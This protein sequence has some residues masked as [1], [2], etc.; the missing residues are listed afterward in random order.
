MGFGRH[1]LPGFGEGLMRRPVWL[2]ECSCQG[3]HFFPQDMGTTGPNVLPSS[4]RTLRGEN[5]ILCY[6]GDKSQ[7]TSS[8]SLLMSGEKGDRA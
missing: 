3:A 6:N 8:D 2:A 7:E 1:L 5:M 4:R